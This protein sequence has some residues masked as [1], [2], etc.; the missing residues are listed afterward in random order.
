VRYEVITDV[1]S[2]VATNACFVYLTD[3][4]WQNREEQLS[5]WCKQNRSVILVRMK[6]RIIS[7]FLWIRFQCCTDTWR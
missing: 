2:E 4:W 3:I 1:T 6:S 5:K 7:W